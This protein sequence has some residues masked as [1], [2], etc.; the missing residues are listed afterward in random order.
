MPPPSKPA[1]L[2]SSGVTLEALTQLLTAGLAQFKAPAT[3]DET[4]ELARNWAGR[5]P[6]MYM[7]F[8][9]ADAKNRDFAL[10][11]AVPPGATSCVSLP[12]R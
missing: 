1:A 11:T 6:P 8:V 12:L 10:G 4:I 7:R 2:P 9:R 3:R 5:D